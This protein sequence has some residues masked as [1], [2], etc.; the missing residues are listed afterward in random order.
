MGSSGTGLLPRD[1]GPEG[2]ELKTAALLSTN[3]LRASALAVIL[4][5]TASIAVLVGKQGASVL[6]LLGD[7]LAACFG[8]AA[9]WKTYS[10]EYPPDEQLPQH[11]EG[12]EGPLKRLRKRAIDLAW[13]PA[14]APDDQPRCTPTSPLPVVIA[15]GVLL[16]LT[17]ITLTQMPAAKGDGFDTT[18]ALWGGGATLAAAVVGALINAGRS[19]VAENAL[20]SFSHK[21][22]AYQGSIRDSRLRPLAVEWINRHYDTWLQGAVATAHRGSLERFEMAAADVQQFRLL[23]PAGGRAPADMPTEQ[24]QIISLLVGPFL[25]IRTGFNFFVKGTSFAVGVSGGGVM[26]SELDPTEREIHYT[27]IV[28]IEYVRG[29]SAPQAGGRQGGQPEC[30]ALQ[31][32]LVDGQNTDRYESL[33]EGADSV[34]QAVRKRT[35]AIKAARA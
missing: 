27:D 24:L 33:E 2:L 32:C 22:D 15:A 13:K 26:V 10:I 11:F 14:E 25:G 3:V 5:T 18:R 29:K 7:A 34:V 19:R 28:T 8:A 16:V 1:A 6:A 31:L 9:F 21:W 23:A 17:L 4:L 35:R 20:L 12:L 30:G